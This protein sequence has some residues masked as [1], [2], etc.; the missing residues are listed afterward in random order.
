M[1]VLECA[2][3]ENNVGVVK[4]KVVLRYLYCNKNGVIRNSLFGKWVGL[5]RCVVLNC[6]KYV[7]CKGCPTNNKMLYKLENV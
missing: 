1:V 3:Q 5:S 4:L 7:L 6:N 2:R